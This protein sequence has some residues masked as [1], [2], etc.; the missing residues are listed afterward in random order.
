MSNPSASGT[1]GARSSS[2]FA[3]APLSETQTR[4]SVAD[5]KAMNERAGC[6][7][8][9]LIS[10]RISWPPAAELAQSVPG[11][12]AEASPRRGLCVI[13]KRRQRSPLR[14]ELRKPARNCVDSSTVSLRKPELVLGWAKAPS[15][16]RQATQRTVR[17]SSPDFTAA[18]LAGAGAAGLTGV[19]AAGAG[20][21]WGLA[22]GAATGAGA[23][24]AAAGAAGAAV[25]AAS[26]ALTDGFSRATKPR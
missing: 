20:V 14:R 6:P 12:G 24:A 19:A 23:A 21:D 13:S 11:T 9:S 1:S 26:R 22:A 15:A 4:R 10:P 7:W 16:T 17:L 2:S 25:A 3:G 8:V 5:L 18:Y